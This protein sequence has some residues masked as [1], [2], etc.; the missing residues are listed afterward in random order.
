MLERATAVCGNLIEADN[1]ALWNELKSNDIDGMIDEL[2][3]FKKAH[4]PDDRLWI[5]V[6]GGLQKARSMRNGLLPLPLAW[7][8]NGK[9]N[10]TAWCERETKSRPLA[11]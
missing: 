4:Y 8:R 10:S 5:L 2:M 6:C 9:P 11:S 7:T 3:E 1:P